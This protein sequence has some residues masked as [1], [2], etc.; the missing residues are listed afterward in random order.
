VRAAAGRAGGGGVDAARGADGRT[1]AAGTAPGGGPRTTHRGG[2]S[3]RAGAAPCTP[4]KTLP[5]L[6][7]RARG[8]DAAACP[9]RGAPAEGVARGPA[10]PP[11][12]GRRG[13]P[14]DRPSP[15]GRPPSGGGV[16]GAGTM[17]AMHPS[18]SHGRSRAPSVRFLVPPRGSAQASAPGGGALPVGR[19]RWRGAAGGASVWAKRSTR[20]GSGSQTRAR[21]RSRCGARAAAAKPRTSFR[22]HLYKNYPGRAS[23]WFLN[24]GHCVQRVTSLLDVACRRR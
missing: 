5:W 3:G 2:R 10:R 9:L 7:P 14:P 20:V 17:A 15:A 18:P 4:A 21:T 1:A 6:P 11:G 23:C 13:Q 24:R 8:A 12:G 16:H 22:G 19:R